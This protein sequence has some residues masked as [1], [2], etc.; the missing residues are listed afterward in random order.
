MALCSSYVQVA[1]NTPALIGL[2]KDI[3]ALGSNE[4]R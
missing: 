4:L 1:V 3:M 2:A